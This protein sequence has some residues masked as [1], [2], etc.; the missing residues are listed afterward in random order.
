MQGTY[1]PWTVA[2]SFLI[3][4]FAA[5]VA[6]QFTARVR[7]SAPRR[8]SHWVWLGGLAMGLGIWCMHFIGM[9]AF[10]LPTRILY[11]IP[12]TLLSIVPAV[13][14]SALALYIAGTKQRGAFEILLAAILMGSGICLMHYIGM[15]AITFSPRP[16]WSAPWLIASFLIAVAASALALLLLSRLTWEPTE[17]RLSVHLAAA[18]LMAIGISGMHYAGM[19]ALHLDAGTICSDGPAVTTGTF[20]GPVVT[21]MIT[22]FL[23]IMLSLSNRDRDLA[24]D[25]ARAAEDDANLSREIRRQAEAMAAELTADLRASEKR[26]RHLAF[27]DPLTNLPNR[28]SCDLHLAQLVD[29]PPARGFSLMFADLDGFKELNDSLGHQVGDGVL[30]EIAQRLQETVGQA[31]EVYRFGGD[32]FIIVLE[33][34]TPRAPEDIAADIIRQ[35]SRPLRA[36]GETVGVTVSLGSV[37]FPQDGSSADLLLRRADNAMYH[38]KAGGKNLHLAYQSHMEAS[39]S[40][41]FHLLNDLRQAV[42]LGQLR[43]HYQP[44]IDLPSRQINGVEALVYWHHPQHGLITPTTF[45]P[46]AENSGLIEA[47]GEWVL[48]EA[49]RQA[50][51][52]AREGLPAIKMAINVS[53]VQFRNPKRLCDA[54]Q[55]ALERHQLPASRLE[56][57][58]TERQLMHDPIISIETMQSLRT[59]GVS[60][61]LDDFGTGYSSLSYLRQF[62]LQTI[63]IDRS[64]TE[65]ADQDPTG[66]AIIAAIASLGNNLGL[67]IVAE[68][69]ERESQVEPLLGCGC[70]RAQGFLFGRPMQADDFRALLQS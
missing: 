69:V 27:I 40:Q 6:I 58:L 41:Q 28:S 64:F 36:G 22:A 21:L 10:R 5:L 51:T 62:P 29:K 1:E 3:A 45:I 20:L 59:L 18:A 17:N 60:L 52:W 11:G 48:D 56:L 42:E 70:Y 31:G 44:T 61:A 32:E 25:R 57:E 2:L 43:L 68:G 65:H 16:E 4:W 19:E 23:A 46:V 67:S 7:E 66:L 34:E 38:A 35:I 49:V 47:L 12:L 14:S 54:V 9:Q 24:L 63:K 39:V 8:T 55:S 15:A 37:R 33:T 26:I 50:G 30:I 53:S 13:L